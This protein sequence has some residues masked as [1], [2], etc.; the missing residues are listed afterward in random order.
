MDKRNLEP[1]GYFSKTKARKAGLLFT[2]IL[3]LSSTWL[4]L[5]GCSGL[6]INLQ[7]I[8]FPPE[9]TS[10]AVISPEETASPTT[11]E[12]LPEATPTSAAPKTLTI[13]VPPQFDPEGDTPAGDLLRNRLRSFS[14]DNPGVQVNVRVKTASN[15]LSTLET[16]TASIEPSALPALVALPRADMETAALKA[17]IFP[18][19]EL[20]S[21]IDEPDWYDYAREMALIQGSM[22]GAPFAGDAM[23][24]VY[25]PAKV[26]AAP[27]GWQDILSR[28]QAMLFPAAD[29]KAYITLA[30]YESAGGTILDSQ[31][32]PSIQS[33][34]LSQVLTLYS[35]GAR[36]GVFPSWLSQY[37]TDNQV[38]Q[39]Y[40]DENAQWLITM[41]SNYLNEFP[42]DST[43]ISLP[44][45]GEES[46]TFAESWMWTLSD[47]YPERRELSTKLAEYLTDSDFL[48][49]WT[50]SVGYLPTRPSSLSAWSDQSVQTLLSQVVLSS[51]VPPSEEVYG[52]IGLAFKDATLQIIEEQEDPTIVSQLTAEQLN[53][54]E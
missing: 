22:F 48:T 54:A 27:T 45:L 49:K 20:T 1:K 21:M 52:S 43:A 53:T 40:K 26:G 9:S 7:E 10:A 19:D 39:A 34:V 29:S 37:Q 30:L 13:W 17:L 42:V 5:A 36:Q 50:P 3:I 14:V 38:W 46:Y 24:L 28:G 32:S 47:P 23:L 8:L 18:M 44:S 12:A 51:H 11:V 41:S 25:R 6:P 2:L 35:E 16:A 4:S 15:L 33:D 31:N